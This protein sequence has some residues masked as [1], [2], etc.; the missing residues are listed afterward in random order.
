MTEG[1]GMKQI[2]LAA[3]IVCVV[4]P[5]WGNVRFLVP[6]VDGR[7]LLSM[8]QQETTD[9]V[10]FCKGYIIG[11]KDHIRSVGGTCAPLDVPY[12]QVISITIRW[13]QNNPQELTSVASFLIEVALIEAFGRKCLK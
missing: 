8:C 10:A 9:A 1:Y 7:R 11:A 5:A 2:I 6:I 3:L 13:L 4:S 12:E